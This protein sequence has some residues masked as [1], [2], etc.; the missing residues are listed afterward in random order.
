MIKSVPILDKPVRA[1]LKLKMFNPGTFLSIF[2]GSLSLQ[3]D[4]S[5]SLMMIHINV[6]NI[7]R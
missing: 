5:S 6:E 3:K 4:S 2:L 1:R 7:R